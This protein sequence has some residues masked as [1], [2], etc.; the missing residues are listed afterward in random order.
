MASNAFHGVQFS[1]EQDKQTV[2]DALIYLPDLISSYDPNSMRFIVKNG[3]YFS[4]LEA[5]GKRINIIE[6]SNE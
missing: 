4:R 2:K 6:V 5:I 1:N 3:V